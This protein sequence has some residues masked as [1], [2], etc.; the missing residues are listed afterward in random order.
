MEELRHARDVARHIG[1][2]LCVGALEVHIGHERGPTVSWAG[3]EDG[4]EV[5]SLDR[6]VHV[7]VEEVQ[8]RGGA[9]VAE[10][11]WLH[12]LCPE[13]LAQKRIVKEVDLTDR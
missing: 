12:V 10:E 5:P 1:V 3:D 6:A 13:R 11:A 9:P 2:D 4:V 8:S 7:R